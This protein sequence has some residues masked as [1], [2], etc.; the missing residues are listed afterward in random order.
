MSDGLPFLS[1]T[2]SDLHLSA[3]VTFTPFGN[4]TLDSPD[5][6]QALLTF[7]TIFDHRNVSFFPMLVRVSFLPACYPFS[8]AHEFPPHPTLS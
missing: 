6:V 7:V 3:S 8:A 1:A 2:V 5:S 4:G